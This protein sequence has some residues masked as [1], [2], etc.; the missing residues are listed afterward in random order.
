MKVSKYTVNGLEN[1]NSAQNIKQSIRMYSG[2]HAIRVDK[3]SNTITIDYDDEQ[4]SN[5]DIENFVNLSG[6]TVKSAE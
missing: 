6:L 1:D 5:Q 3:N 2:I 4:Y